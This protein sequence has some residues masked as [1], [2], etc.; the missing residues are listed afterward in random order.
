MTQQIFVWL[1]TV[2]QF[3]VLEN[4]LQCDAEWLLDREQW[5]VRRNNFKCAIG[6]LQELH[7]IAI[8]H[9][10]SRHFL[11]MVKIWI[12]RRLANLD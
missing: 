10:E 5:N 1:G 4:S 11:A 9:E 7:R 6:W 2:P 3:E 8:R 12:G